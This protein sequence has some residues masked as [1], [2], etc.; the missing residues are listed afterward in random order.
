MV[1]T[2]AVSVAQERTKLQKVIEALNGRI[3]AET[4]LN[5]TKEQEYYVAGL[6]DALEIVK[7]CYE[8]EF[9]IGCTYF[10]L[11]LDRFNNAQVEEMRLYRINKKKRWSYCFT[12]YLTGDTVNPDLVLCSEGC[13]KLRVFT[14]RE[15]AEKNKSSVLWRHK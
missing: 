10:V 1:Q 7:S 6:S 14:S 5:M 11:T 12:R 8:S 15:E 13:L 9:V 2:V 4:T 3:T